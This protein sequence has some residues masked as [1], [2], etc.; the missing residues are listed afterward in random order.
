MIT[1]AARWRAAVRRDLF[2]V[3]HGDEALLAYLESAYPGSAAV[4]RFV[5]A[6]GLLAFGRADVTPVIL[7]ELPDPDH[8]ARI[9]ARAIDDLMPTGGN[10][11][12]DPAAARDWYEA[13]GERLRWDARE[14]RYRL[15]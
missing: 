1:P 15:S 11:A 6:V 9:L 10:A 2:R 12:A 13:H 4:E 7:A 8:P 14:G 5:L 3:P